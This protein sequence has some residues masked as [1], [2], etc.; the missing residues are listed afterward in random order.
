MTRADRIIQ[1]MI[2]LED[3]IETD[4]ESVEIFLRLDAELTAELGGSSARIAAIRQK[5]K[6][7]A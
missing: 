3:F 4:P 7:A 5:I 1:A 6:S 2:V